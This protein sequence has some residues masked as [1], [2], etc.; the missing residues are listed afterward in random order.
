MLT[1]A[2]TPRHVAFS[3]RLCV[4]VCLQVCVCVFV[5]DVSFV[6]FSS[7]LAGRSVTE[8]QQR[9]FKVDMT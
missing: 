2:D 7:L 8:N 6:F 1:K 9:I 3:F 4:T 5:Y